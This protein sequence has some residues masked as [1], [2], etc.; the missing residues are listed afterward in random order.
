MMKTMFECAKRGIKNFKSSVCNLCAKIEDRMQNYIM[1]EQKDFYLLGP[2]DDVIKGKE[3][4]QALEWAL[5]EQKN[6]NIALAGNYG[7]GKSSIINTYI[8]QHPGVR[9]IHLSLASFFSEKGEKETEGLD[10]DEKKIEESILKQLFYKVNYRMIPQS[11]YRKLHRAKNETI[12]LVLLC[13]VLLSYFFIY[14]FLPELHQRGVEQIKYLADYHK[15]GMRQAWTIVNF[16]V[17]VCYISIGGILCKILSGYV[18][19]ELNIMEQASLSAR[20]EKETSIFNKNMDEIM[21]F[22]E[23]TKYNIVFIEDL[24]RFNN[25]DI[26]IKL[27]ELNDLLNKNE[28][29][30]RRIA[31]VY[32]VRDDMFISDDRIKFFDFIIPVIPIVN[33]TNSNDI[34]LSWLNGNKNLVISEEFIVKISPYIGDMRMLHNIINEFMIYRKTL[35]E[36]QGLRLQEEKLFSLI[37]YKN[38]FPRDFS[39]LQNEEGIIKQAF[40]DKEIYSNKR[41]SSAKESSNMGDVPI[42]EFVENYAHELS[43]EVRKNKL[44]IFMLRNGYIDETYASYINYFY[45]TNITDDGMNFILSIRNHERKE[46]EYCLSNIGQIVRR[47]TEREFEQKEILNYQLLE[48]LL[49]NEPKSRK[50]ENFIKQLADGS[51]L[52]KRFIYGFVDRGIC[53]N[54]FIKL[55]CRFYDNFWDDIARDSMPEERKNG[56]FGLII[57][58]AESKDIERMNVKPW[59]HLRISRWFE[60]RENILI[61][62]KNV[63]QDKMKELID[64]LDIKFTNLQ[65]EGV[66]EELLSFIFDNNY[67]EINASMIKNVIRFIAPENLLD[68]DNAH[69]TTILRLNYRPLIDYIDK[70]FEQYV[71][72][73][74]LEQKSNVSEKSTVV[75]K[76]IAKLHANIGLCMKLI[77]KENIIIEDIESFYK[78][79]EI[80]KKLLDTRKMQ[81]SVN[82]II[83]YWESWGLCEELIGYLN[84]EMEKIVELPEVQSLPAELIEDILTSALET[85]AYC[86]FISKCKIRKIRL[87]LIERIERGRM[88]L[89][90][91]N[92]YW[93]LSP[94]LFGQIRN[95]YPEL[96]WGVLVNYK[97][98][99]LNDVEDYIITTEEAERL[100]NEVCLTDEE[101]IIILTRFKINKLSDEAVERI[102]KITVHLN[103]RVVEKVWECLPQSKRLRWLYIQ[104][105]NYTKDG[106][107]NKFKEMGMPYQSLADRTRTHMVILDS[108]DDD[109]YLMEYLKSINYLTR[110]EYQVINGE[111]KIACWVKKSVI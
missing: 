74:C 22:F 5:K 84:M 72:K 82:N 8:K 1:E 67:Y 97:T 16:F 96:V 58:Y 26:F 70:N 18:V 106:F 30:H 71:D 111:E 78:E 60:E 32:A 51:D 23:V 17:V 35:I 42:K 25:V 62:L 7:S 110:I 47:V 15:I 34:L 33:A 85:Q 86:L 83:C 21:Y 52:S 20:D 54:I 81:M 37:V 9:Y 45:P 107:S 50:C 4:L 69:Y 61:E 3:S 48:Y 91:K 102:A 105:A 103:K 100:I 95:V 46:P 108:T 2:S 89:L 14:F 77:E 101:M 6:H 28:N 12:F 98:V 24:E 90:I 57:Y 19:K 53:N 109:R 93:V 36:E 31:F 10:Y 80:W 43:E 40:L 13:V 92:K 38:L 66:D 63:S 76:M 55:L 79:R 104:R 59:H 68:L 88:Q 64:C 49:V 73:V 39:K 11:R 65:C 99:I 56:L 94:E 75:A 44:A 29:I 27:R 41:K 87:E